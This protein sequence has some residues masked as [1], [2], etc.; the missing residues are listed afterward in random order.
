M[1]KPGALKHVCLTGTGKFHL[2]TKTG[3]QPSPEREALFGARV[4]R[5]KSCQQG[6]RGIPE[7][8]GRSDIQ[9]GFLRF[10]EDFLNISAEVLRMFIVVL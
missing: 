2:V 5:I 3:R 1:E 7:A 6:T 10:P 8:V 4:R 9:K